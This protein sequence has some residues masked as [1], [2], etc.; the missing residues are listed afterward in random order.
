[1]CQMLRGPYAAQ[2]AE[3]INAEVGDAVE[4][5]LV[6]GHG[7]QR[8]PDR[9]KTVRHVVPSRRATPCTDAASSRWIWRIAHEHARLDN[10]GRGAAT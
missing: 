7:V 8:W 1:M 9:G 2:F 4:P 6:V 3:A 5:A 10:S